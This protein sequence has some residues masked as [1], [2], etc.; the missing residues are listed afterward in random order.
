MHER[1]RE[2]E[3]HEP[4]QEA[5][6]LAELL[7]TPEGRTPPAH[8]GLT[9]EGERE[10]L[11][12]ANRVGTP[13]LAPTD[14]ASEPAPQLGAVLLRLVRRYP[15]PSLLAGAGLLLLIRRARR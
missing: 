5:D 15:L 10:L 4:D 14:T 2:T 1:E 13:A 7:S 6:L 12:E 8:A 9:R 3:M 11:R